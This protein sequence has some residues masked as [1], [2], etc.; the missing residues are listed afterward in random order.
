MSLQLRRAFQAKQW[1]VNNFKLEAESRPSHFL[2][3][4]WQGGVVWP[5]I[6]YTEIA[7]GSELVVV[8]QARAPVQRRTGETTAVL[9]AIL[10]S[11]LALFELAFR[12]QSSSATTRRLDADDDD[13]RTPEGGLGMSIMSR[14]FP[15][16]LANPLLN[17][18]SA[19][20]PL[21]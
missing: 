18:R 19:R 3:Y 15:R 6:G 12:E 5:T 21:R 8:V 2:T 16:S 14:Q 13:E 20:A 1:V 7:E 11:V 10:L 4:S 9:P 17:V